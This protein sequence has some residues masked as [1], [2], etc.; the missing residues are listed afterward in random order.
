MNPQIFVT[1]NT[2]KGLY[3][4]T[5]LPFGVASAPV[6]FQKTMDTMEQGIAG[7]ICY[8]DD[9]LITAATDAEHLKTLAQVL[10]RLQQ[11]GVRVKRPK[12]KFMQSSVE[13]LGHRIDAEGLHTTEHKLQAIRE[14]PF[15]HNV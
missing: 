1:I 4:Y 8:I 2:H 5:C 11:N 9:I 12:C 7:V 14:A 13:Y 15:P 10:Q 6:V 3:S